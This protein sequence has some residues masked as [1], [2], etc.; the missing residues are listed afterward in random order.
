VSLGLLA[1]AG[2]LWTDE[3]LAHFREAVERGARQEEQWKALVGKYE[4]E[5]PE[6]GSP[7]RSIMK[8]ELPE[9]WEAHL[10]KFADPKPVATRVASGEVINALAPHLPMLIGGSA[11]LGVSNNTDIKGGGD[12]EA[13]S[14]EGRILHFGVR[15]HA[16][17]STLTGIS[18]NGGLIPYGGTFLT[19]SD[20]M[21]PAIRLAALSE[22]QVIY[23]FTHDSIGLGE[24]GPTHQPVEHLAALRA[25]PN[26]NVF[27]PCDA[28][29]TVE[30]WQLALEGRETPSVLALTRQNL[31]QLRRSLD[32]RNKCVHG[33]YEISPAEGKAQKDVQVSIFATGSE[34]SIAVEAQKLLAAKGVPARVVSVPCFELFQSAPD[35]VRRTVIGDAP[36]KVGVEAAVRQG[37]DALIGP[38]GIFVGMSSFGASGPYKELY[39]H[40]GITAAK[41]AEAALSRLPKR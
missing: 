8:G 6:L 26:L 22:V 29:E 24:D 10:P 1:G 33:A 18:L 14:Y 40:F 5:H 41:I 13:G 30:C 28:V 35:E 7:W 27:R 2:L 4:E 9:G 39:S 15:E 32:E 36:V 12:F 11:D 20:Y 3:A 31:P 16:M 34:V 25:I 38:D 23:V 17:G 37:W 19:F 21:R